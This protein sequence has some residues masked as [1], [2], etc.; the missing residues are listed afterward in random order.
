[1]EK[2]DNAVTA[3]TNLFGNYIDPKRKLADAPNQ[4]LIEVDLA[5]YEERGLG[6][7]LMKVVRYRF[8]D[9]GQYGLEGISIGADTS[10]GKI[11][12][13]D[14]SPVLVGTHFAVQSKV[15]ADVIRALYQ[16]KLPFELITLGALRHDQFESLDELVQ[17]IEMY[18]KCASTIERNKLYCGFLPKSA[19]NLNREAKT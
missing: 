2:I 12:Y 6:K 5:E 10:R 1:M 11:I 8:V 9:I 15:P 4:S 13:A 7:A 19:R 17:F 3:K 16:R 14:M 18:H